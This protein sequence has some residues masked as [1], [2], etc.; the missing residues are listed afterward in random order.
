MNK[1]ILQ[2]LEFDKIKEQFAVHL[3]TAQGK[4]ELAALKPLTDPIK[5]QFLFD[6]LADFHLVSQENGALNLSKT[7]DISE[8]LRRLEL[9][10]T[11][12]GREFIEL[13]KVI[14]GSI[15]ITRYFEAAENVTFDHLQVTVDK[16]IDLSLLIKKL[17]IF[18]S[19][20]IL[21]DNASNELMHIRGRIKRNQS[22]IKKI[23][24]ELLNKNTAN[25][26][27][28]I[29]TVRNDRQ[30]LP[31]RSDSKNKIQVCS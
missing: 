28:S 9:D 12:S 13:K 5:I 30:V 31:V 17:D 8:F 3:V 22:D 6:E 29:I 1:K 20:G 23:M 7:S 27:E 10:A 2:I 11:L 15:N 19:S 26:T 18:D 16:L 21:Y 4:E 25:L 14:Q 24:Q